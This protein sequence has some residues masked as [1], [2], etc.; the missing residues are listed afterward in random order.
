MPGRTD[1]EIKNLWNSSIKKKL[2]QRGID[3]NTHKPLSDAPSGSNEK[4]SQGSYLEDKP[5][6]VATTSYPL[7]DNSTP[8]THEFFLNRFVTKQQPE[9]HHIPGFLPFNYTQRQ[10]AEIFFTDSKSS[11]E[12]I[13]GY[14]NSISNPLLSAPPPNNW[15]NGGFFGYQPSWGLTECTKS[16]NQIDGVESE[17]DYIKWNDQF[18]PFLMG[19]S[20]TESKPEVNFA[21]SHELYN[22]QQSVDT[23]NNNSNKQFQRISTSYGYFS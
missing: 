1:N 19:K 13:S 3:P 11:P 4:N 12:M 10:P 7:I 6:A 15:T 18:L 22:G 2:K 5:E 9:S 23:Y 20:S 8:A 14:N 17:Q 16:E 21:V